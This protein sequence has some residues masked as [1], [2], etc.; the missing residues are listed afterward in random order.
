VVK[1]NLNLV[2]EDGTWKLVLSGSGDVDELL[3]DLLTEPP[4]DVPTVTLPECYCED[5]ECEDSPCGCECSGD[6]SDQ[7]V[8]EPE[9]EPEPEP[10]AEKHEDQALIDELIK[11]QSLRKLPPV[12]IAAR[13]FNPDED[14]L[15]QGVVAYG[16]VPLLNFKGERDIQTA[17]IN[18]CNL[19]G[20]YTLYGLLG[21][22]ATLAATYKF[23]MDE[24]RFLYSLSY[25][26]VSINPEDSVQVVLDEETAKNWIGDGDTDDFEAFGEETGECSLKTPENTPYD[27]SEADY[28]DDEDGF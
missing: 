14:G 1:L 4:E 26:R 28:E 9:P 25:K 18:W 12:D 21:T 27:A 10:E 6:C 17:C 19:Q 7:D 13:S 20:A 3:E 2:E 15:P 5:C 24:G 8:A 11:I 22:W 23:Q 16:N